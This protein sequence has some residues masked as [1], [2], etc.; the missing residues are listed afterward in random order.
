[1]NDEFALGQVAASEQRLSCSNLRLAVCSSLDLLVHGGAVVILNAS[2]YV[3]F[4]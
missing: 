2:R 3:G 4:L 1:M